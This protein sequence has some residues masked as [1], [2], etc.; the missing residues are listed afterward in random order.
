MTS[1]SKADFSDDINYVTP[2]FAL[3]DQSYLETH[4]IMAYSPVL[5]AAFGFVAALVGFAAF[6]QFQLSRSR[7]RIALENGCR[8]IQGRFPHKDPIFGTDYMREGLKAKANFKGLERVSGLLETLG[9]TYS[10][11]IFHKTLIVTAEPEVLKAL[12]FGK[13][14]DIG[15]GDVARILGPLLG[16]GI[17]TTD[18]EYWQHSRAMIRPNFTRTQVSNLE[19]LEEY[20]QDMFKLIPRDQSE[21]DLQQL[22]FRLTMDSATEF[23]FGQSVHSLRPDLPDIPSGNDFAKAFDLAQHHC[24]LRFRKGLLASIKGQDKED[25]EA[26]KTCHAYV[27][28]FVDDA[29]RYRHTFDPASAEKERYT[30]L[31]ELAK[32]TQDPDR[33]RD[34]VMNLLLAGRDT[35]ASLLSNLFHHLAKRPDIWNRLHAE[36]A[37]LEGALPSFEQL[38]DLKF[39][40]RCM[41]ECKQATWPY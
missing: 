12:L 14:N 13:F 11:R 35:T 18:G 17:F 31:H 10:L 34:E 37:T 19:A 25:V 2:C 32:E 24:S 3:R 39:L 23:L 8:P 36:V 6:Q 15:R 27:Q 9:A 29:I 28:R 7:R 33:L 40:Q 4:S 20:L 5:I 22:F 26:I 41:K 1:T 16:Q 30:F 21:V 38:K